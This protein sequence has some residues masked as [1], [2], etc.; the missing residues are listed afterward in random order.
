M[1][2]IIFEKVDFHYPEIYTPVFEKVSICMDTQWRLGLIGR[3]GR[4][5]YERAI[6]RGLMYAGF[7]GQLLTVMYLIKAVLIL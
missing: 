7:I 6:D 2:K 4:L 1:G 5:M 3:N